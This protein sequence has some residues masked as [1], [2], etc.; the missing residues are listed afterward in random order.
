M[1]R[2]GGGVVGALVLAA[3][4]LTAT[5]HADIT[6]LAPRSAQQGP[7]LLDGRVLWSTRAGKSGI[8]VFGRMASG[9]PVEVVA[10][11][12]LPAGE[13]L[14]GW[15]L[16]AAPHWIGLRIGDR[17]LGGPPGAALPIV[18]SR[19]PAGRLMAAGRDTWATTPPGFVTLERRA[20]TRDDQPPRDV[21]VT[22]GMGGHRTLALP[23]G[24]E[25]T[26]LAVNGAHA[27]V[28][29]AD[30]QGLPREVDVLDLATGAV[31]RRVEMGRF[32]IELVIS[33]SLSPEGDLAI[34]GEDGAG[35]DWL[36]W[37]PRGAPQ[38]DVVTVADDFGLM[39]AAKG[40]IA[41]VGPNQA[42]LGEGHRVVVFEPRP[43]DE[44][45]R[46]LFR[47]PPANQIEP[48]DF[49][50]EHVAWGIQD[51]CQLVANATPG[52]SNLVMPKGPCVR[53]LVTTTIFGTPK[54]R[55]PAVGIQFGCL[56][57]PRKRCRILVRALAFPARGGIGRA[58]GVLDGR[59]PR[60][61]S[62]VL[63]VPISRRSAARLRR[64]TD[65]TGFV[66]TV[67]DPDGKR[68]TDF[69]I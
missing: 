64:E 6:A 14:G 24:A 19:V 43:G 25:P 53:T 7:I 5:A 32:S 18:R 63:F 21:V 62:R 55:G 16:V 27:A 13:K 35:V 37:A 66:Y 30:R 50:G 1:R 41:M 26:T 44:E 46:V 38:F 2:A 4:A 48:L 10:R 52:D 56:T 47:G 49:D 45:P 57:A 61:A 17:L 12:A 60:G 31:E 40:R 23:A 69:I 22:S 20:G 11:A 58:I 54:L 36:G 3:L 68:H 33:V 39:Q 29:I 8:R 42:R 65:M 67:I 9:G 28:V 59:V 34:T 15:E 51:S